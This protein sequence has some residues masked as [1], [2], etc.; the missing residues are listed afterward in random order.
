[1]PLFMFLRLFH[2]YGPIGSVKRACDSAETP[3]R[4]MMPIGIRG[5]ITNNII[6]MPSWLKRSVYA[7]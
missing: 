3:V 4:I 2:L 7:V 1:M 5:A 6:V